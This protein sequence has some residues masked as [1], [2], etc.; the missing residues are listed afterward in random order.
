MLK[1]QD[2]I[3]HLN[4][5]IPD[6]IRDI[7]SNL[8]NI[9][10]T[11]SRSIRPEHWFLPIIG[12][13]FDGHDFI[14]Q[15]MEK[16]CQGFFYQAD[17][18]DQIPS[19]LRSRGIEIPDSLEFF[20]GLASFWR[21]LHK[22]KVVAITGSNGKTTAKEMLSHILTKAGN[23]LYTKGSYNNEIGV[24]ITLCQL[25]TDHQFAVIEMGARHKGDIEA[26][27]NIANPDICIVL[28]IGVA[29]LGEFGSRET[30]RSTKQ[31]M[32][33]TTRKDAIAIVP[34]D[35][36]DTVNV[37][38]K[39][40][41][42]VLTFGLEE[43]DIQVK[44]KY[45]TDGAM[46]LAITSPQEAFQETVPVYHQAYPINFAASV[47]A[48]F[49]LDLS[50]LS[51]RQGMKSFGGVSQ[52]FSISRF[53]TMT[54]IDDTYNAN[55]QS[56]DA[57]LSSVNAAFPNADTIL[58]L[59]DMLE[60]GDESQQAHYN[61]GYYCAE[62]VRPK[63]LVAIGPLSRAML[64][65]ARKGGI[66]EDKLL[67]FDSADDFVPQLEEILQKGNLLYAKASNGIKLNR[68]IQNARQILE[69]A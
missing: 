38:K 18:C 23:T 7:P 40:H 16:G 12:E 22:A 4:A 63:M 67:H 17:H 28:N 33:T 6:E 44:L 2:L 48:S 46:T 35:D 52:R 13:T 5:T 50:S 1:R 8:P 66:S 14:R 53:P 24:P 15:A 58:V 19:D 3:Q 26:L 10:Q 60:L 9:I 36:S 21:N 34:H 42:R 68:I 29:H 51:I 45:L 55:P 59:G 39:H 62:S 37:A 56:M 69:K 27:C 43:G 25:T 64:D 65:G 61:V 30:L 47:A 54:L 49:G 31:E 32:L 11:D 20:Q 41:D 57:G